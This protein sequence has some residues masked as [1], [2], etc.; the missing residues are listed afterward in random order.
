MGV[1]TVAHGLAWFGIGFGVLEL[2]APRAT[3]RTAGLEGREGVLRLYGLREIASGVIVL[4]SRNPA[5][6]LWAR[7]A[8]DLLDGVLLGRRMGPDNS[9]RQRTMLASL[10]VLP[11]VV[12]DAVYARPRPR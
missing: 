1:R 2:L 6:W 10:A 5:S 12:L 9:H 11:I 4:A 3:A 7:V 8:G